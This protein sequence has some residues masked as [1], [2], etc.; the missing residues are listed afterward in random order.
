MDLN[1]WPD[2]VFK[3]DYNLL[4]LDEVKNYIDQHQRLPEMPSEQDVTKNGLN[5]REIVKLQ[6]KN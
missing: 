5:L 6:T 4:P 2:Y 1:I 3:P